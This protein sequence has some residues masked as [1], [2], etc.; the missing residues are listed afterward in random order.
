[1]DVSSDKFLQLQDALKGLFISAMLST[2]FCYESLF[3]EGGDEHP[4]IILPLLNDATSSVNTMRAIYITFYDDIAHQEFD[5]FFQHF[6][7]F[8]DEVLTNFRTNH[9][10]QWSSIEYT[11]MIE[12]AMDLAGLLAI[13]DPEFL[14]AKVE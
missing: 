9:S 13:K 7:V 4:E 14:K 11:R 12:W 1:M 8:K 6:D 2:K 3:E 5:E 10:H